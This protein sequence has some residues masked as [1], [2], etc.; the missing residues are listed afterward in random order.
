[1]DKKKKYVFP[2]LKHADDLIEHLWSLVMMI[3][4]DRKCSPQVL[5]SEII[6]N[7]N[8]KTDKE[9]KNELFYHFINLIFECNSTNESGSAYVSKQV[10]ARD[11][12]I[13]FLKTV[14]INKL[15]VL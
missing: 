7:K 1:M 15:L 9:L 11:K 6:L 4:K 10:F 8:I 3:C 13:P 2:P 5:A 12:H 14:F